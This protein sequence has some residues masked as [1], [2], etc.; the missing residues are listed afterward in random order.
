MLFKNIK[1]FGPGMVVHTH[2]P[3]Y[4]GG[5]D[6]RIVIQGQLGQKPETLLDKYKAQSFRGVAQ[7]VEHLPSKC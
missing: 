7:V 5:R 1:V 4:S 2:N 3:S 6:R